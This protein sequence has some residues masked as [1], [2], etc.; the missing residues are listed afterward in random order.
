MSLHDMAGESCVVWGLSLDVLFIET[1]AAGLWLISSVSQ[2]SID[3]KSRFKA[4]Q[5]PYG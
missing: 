5:R 1:C 3:W 2:G 4:V